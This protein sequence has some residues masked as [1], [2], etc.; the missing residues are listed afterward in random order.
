MQQDPFATY[1][2]V[3]LSN[4]T[5]TLSQIHFHTYFSTFS[6]RAF[7]D[8]VILNYPPYAASLSTILN[9][10]SSAVIEGYLVV[11]AALALSP[12]LGM[13]TEAWMAHRTLL[14]T[15]TGIKKGAVGDRAE[16]CLGR[17]EASLG[18]ASGR[19][20]VQ[21]TFG[22]TSKNKATKVITSELPSVILPNKLITHTGHCQ[23]LSKP[24]RNLCV[25]LTGWMDSLPKLLLRRYSC[26][27]DVSASL[28]YDLSGRC[29]SGQ[30][31][32]S[33]FTGHR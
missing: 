20:F 25:I 10:T 8:R 18:F 12:Y 19:F 23:I 24:S 1:N 6:P 2:P 5:D 3:Q 22:G 16:Y 4:L 21:E 7:P 30:S 17:V 33:S 14:E 27:V 31:R 28:L 26:D 15:L 11:R 13:S 32:V 9:E 29:Y